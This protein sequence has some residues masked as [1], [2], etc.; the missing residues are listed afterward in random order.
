MNA[1]I[2]S[3]ESRT[4]NPEPREIRFRRVSADPDPY[5]NERNHPEPRI[6]TPEPRPGHLSSPKKRT[7]LLSVEHEPAKLFFTANS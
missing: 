5:R 3:P 4:P 2:P 1:T 7:I 6:P